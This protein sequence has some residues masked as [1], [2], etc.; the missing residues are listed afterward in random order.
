VFSVFS[1]AKFVGAND[2]HSGIFTATYEW[3]AIALSYLVFGK[4]RSHGGRASRA[5]QSTN[6]QLTHAH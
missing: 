6:A 1:V 2:Q 5:V 3:R 4:A